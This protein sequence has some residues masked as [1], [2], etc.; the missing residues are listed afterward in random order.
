MQPHPPTTEQQERTPPDGAELDLLRDR[1]G[2]S[3]AFVF[4]RVE[5]DRYV[6]LGGWGRGVGWAGIVDVVLSEEPYA[7]QAYDHPVPLRIRHDTPRRVFG[8]YYA[9]EAWLV[10]LSEDLLV[11]FGHP[12]HPAEGDPGDVEL[13]DIAAAVAS[14]LDHVSPA[15][16]LADEVEVLHAVQAMLRHDPESVAGAMEHI[17]ASATE[18]LSCD[19]GLMYVPDGNRLAMAGPPH[20]VAAAE[21]AIRG[22]LRELWSR[23][24]HHP[25]CIQDAHDDPLPGV[26]GAATGALSYYAVPVGDPPQAILLVMHT[27]ARPRGFTNLCRDLGLRLAEAAQSVLGTAR[28]REELRRELDRVRADACS[29]RLTGLGNRRA[30]DEALADAAPGVAAGRPAAVLLADLNHLK[31]AND[32]HGHALGDRLLTAF[33][34]VVRSSVRPRDFVA[35]IGGDE[36]AVL[37]PNTDD[38]AAVDVVAGLIAAVD[39]HPGVDGFPLSAAIGWAVCEPGMS[40]VDTQAAADRS[41]YGHKA[42]TRAELPPA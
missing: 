13:L 18:A 24:G 37:M 31:A 38:T 33:S 40:L 14:G 34:D 28:L 22:A 2:A 3:D 9:V 15:K 6:H 10:P 4:R 23:L 30:W 8:P 1:L 12:E 41:M 29:D 25:S 20:G 17:I 36:I 26:L 32:Q 11:V 7:A 5:G 42:R 39:R 27:R 16:R 19:V 35:R 21:D